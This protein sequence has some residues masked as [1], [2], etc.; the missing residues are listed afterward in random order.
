MS[1][2]PG[3]VLGTVTD[4]DDPEG[5]GRVRLTFPSRSADAASQWAPILR[6]LASGGFGL[7]FQPEVG[8]VVLVAF[9]E[10][11][12]ERP[13][14]LGAIFTGDNAPPTGDGKLRMIQS[15][16]GHRIT[17]DDT[18]GAEVLTIEDASGNVIRME[19]SGIT[20]ESKTDLTIKGV[21]VTV[22][23]SAQL[24]AK[25]APIHLNP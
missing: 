8:D 4:T 5:L 24:T 15:Q 11:R 12:V 20:I 14:V 13:Y 9:E 19:Q 6:P 23:A 21:N 17:L 1:R 25:G 2:I 3:L 10:G 7:W 16:S 22:E 18:E